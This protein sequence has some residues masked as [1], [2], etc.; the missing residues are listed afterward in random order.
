MIGTRR[1]V[2][3]QASL[4][5]EQQRYTIGFGGPLMI[6][7]RLPS[8][9]W[10]YDPNSPL[11]RPGGFGAV[12]LGGSSEEPVAVKRLH[13]DAAQA[14]HREM[15]LSLNLAGRSFNHVMPILDAGEDAESGSYF[16]VMPLA[17]GTLQEGLDSGTR[18]SD[19]QAAEVLLQI[20]SGLA[21][22]ED[23]VHRD[24]K[25][26]NILCHQGTWKIADF[27]IARFVEESTSLAT[28][29]ECLSPPYA[30]PEQWELQRATSATDIYALG[31]IGYALL[32]G[33]PPFPGPSVA[34]YRQQHLFS[35]PTP[36]N[37]TAPR[38]RSLL[39]MMLRKVPETQPSLARVRAILDDV[40]N[41]ASGPS[42]TPGFQSL[43]EANVRV[44][45]TESEE[46]RRRRE[47]DALIAAR[48]N[49][50]LQGGLILKEAISELGQR[51]L[52]AAPS[53]RLES[54]AVW[55]VSLGPA[56]LWIRPTTDTI[57]RDA[58]RLSDWDV[59]HGATIGVEQSNPR[60]V[61]SAS[62]W[63][64]KLPN[65]TAYRWVEMSYFQPFSQEN[66]A[67]YAITDPGQADS[68]AGR[69]MHGIQIA[70]GPQPIDDENLTEF[71]ERWAA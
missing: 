9:E 63:Y 48:K 2:G 61:W 15:R 6:R 62:L 49:V 56:K 10:A 39:S 8:R 32:T 19:R 30:A 16:V 67:P 24:L 27:G 5:S 38:L 59:V 18:F 47:A 7:I 52:A 45:E 12:F 34:D 43:I 25:P 54:S 35:A 11:G 20:A 31:C 70:W 17:Q 36:P 3:W 23:I 14:A 60:Y 33:Q 68:A 1:N 22:V 41:D 51:I 28:L 57:P 58:F 64:A 55:S 53:A 29:K 71:C 4:Q 69:G 21:E 42:R 50:F 26:A 44:T 65:A 66:Q 13:L 37:Q 40:K 46:V